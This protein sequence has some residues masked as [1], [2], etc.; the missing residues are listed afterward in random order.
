M[1]GDPRVPNKAQASYVA[2]KAMYEDGEPKTEAA[3][4]ALADFDPRAS[5]RTEA[6]NRAISTGW[7]RKLEDGRIA[8]TEFAIEFFDTA[9]EAPKE[10]YTGQEAGP[11]QIDL[12]NRDPWKSNL[13]PRGLRQDVPDWSVRDKK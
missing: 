11:R 5:N 2:A 10:K 6:L 12:L 4:Y 8:L 1:S 9:D 13:N 7:L 3:F